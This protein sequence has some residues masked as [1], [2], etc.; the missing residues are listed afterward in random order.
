MKVHLKNCQRPHRS[1]QNGVALVLTLLIISML[2]V[3][4]VGF[5]SV[6]RLEQMAARNYTYQAA[7]EQMAQLATSQAIEALTQAVEL[8]VGAGMYAVQ[9]GRLSPVGEDAVPLFSQGGGTNI[10]A[11]TSYGFVTGNTGDN[12]SVGLVNVPR[13]DG[14]VMGRTGFYIADETVKLPVNF[15][16]PPRGSLNP[17]PP[18]PFSIKGVGPTLQDQAVTAFSNVLSGS[19]S[20][21]TISNWSYFF[22]TEQLQGIFGFGPEFSR[23]TT[24][25]TATNGSHGSRT[26]WGTDKVQIN[27][28]NTLPLTEASV[29]ALAARLSDG[30]LT[31]LFGSHFGD[32]YGTE[33]VRQLAANMLQLRSDHWAGGARFDGTD[34][35]LGSGLIAGGGK[36]TNGIPTDYLGYVPFPMI[37]HIAVGAIHGWTAPEKMSVMVVVECE[38]FNPYPVAFPGGGGGRI[39]A[40]ID[41]ARGPMS[42]DPGE[43]RGPEGT[44]RSEAPHNNYTGASDAWGDPGA[45]NPDPGR[46][47][48]PSDGV[49]SAPLPPIGPNGRATVLLPFTFTFDEED[50][51]AAIGDILCIIDNV[52]LLADENDPASIRDWCSG[53]DFFNALTTGGA[54]GPAQFQLPM[55]GGRGPYG[56]AEEEEYIVLTPEDAPPPTQ[57]LVRF[58]PRMRPSLAVSR[59]YQSEAPGGAWSLEPY[60]AP[61]PS[62]VSPRNFLDTAIPADPGFTN[63]LS[64][65]VYNTNLPPTLSTSDSTYAMAADLGKVF[66]GWPWRTLRMQPQPPEEENAIPDWVLL[67]MIDFTDGTKPLTT[68]NPNSSYASAGAAVVGFGAGLRSQL[69]VLT[70]GAAISNVA[71]PLNPTLVRT[72][73]AKLAG[74]TNGLSVSNLITQAANLEW[75]GASSWG[76]R[77]TDEP[78]EFPTTALMLPSEI[79]EVAGFADYAG[80]GDNFK[81]NEYR[82]GSL[83]PGLST[84]SRFFKIYAVGEAF[85]GTTTQNVAATA[86]LQTLVEVDDSTDP[87]SITTIYQY[88]PAD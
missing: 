78:M 67:D 54:N 15:A 51:S 40:Q 58:D 82:I 69:D 48:N 47:L 60:E 74:L 33:G 5:V 31:D 73:L 21:N 34:P 26:P 37:E 49:Q 86:L 29:D 43:R 57:K 88:P 76:G 6:S 64:M 55:T 53:N 42:Y 63:N 45:V 83:F 35:V 20:N 24:V 38:L 12:I 46:T 70:N 65:A 7:A 72:N 28:T 56:S 23:R 22:T 30:R 62:A 52:R 14:S 25:A 11:A 71:S 80:Q 10:N 87:I 1:R 3:V 4:V 77:R 2:V 66:T 68:V 61:A 18:R 19:F 36:K 44:P 79:V 75:S 81:L 8:G 27:N 84:K 13:P 32:K 9:S 59:I 41:K 17:V 50:V 39:Y 85:E 16:A